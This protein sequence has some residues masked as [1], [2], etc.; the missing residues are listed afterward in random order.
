[1]NKHFAEHVGD[2][3]E[4][5]HIFSVTTV[6]LIPSCPHQARR[7]QLAY[8]GNPEISLLIYMIA[9]VLFCIIKLL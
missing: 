2:V 5:Q 7:M 4:C 8:H 1:M 3:A 6:S 9:A